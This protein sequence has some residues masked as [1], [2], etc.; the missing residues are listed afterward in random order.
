MIV[1]KLSSVQ[2]KILNALTSEKNNQHI[3][4]PKIKIDPEL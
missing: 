4:D 3:E 2:K 1:L